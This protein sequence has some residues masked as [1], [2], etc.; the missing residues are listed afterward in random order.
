MHPSRPRRRWRPA[1]ATA[2]SATAL[3][4]VAGCA[5]PAVTGAAS[6]AVAGPTTAATGIPSPSRSSA[7]SAPSTTS[8]S[9]SSAPST[10]LPPP[11]KTS[12]S[13]SNGPTS[14]PPGGILSQVHIGGRVEVKGNTVQYS[15]PGVYFEGRFRGTG[16]GIVLNDSAADYE[17]QIDGATVATLVTP[18]QTTRWVNGLSNTDHAVRLVKRNDSPGNVSEFAGFVAAPGGAILTGPGARSRQIEF[19]GDSLTVGYGNTSTSRDCTG[20]QIHRT[21]DTDLSYGAVTARQ[22]SADY[23][24]NA[25]SG[26]GMVRNFNGGSPGTTYRTYYDQG[27]LNGSGDVWNP[28]TWRPQLVVVY[29]GTNDFS[30]ALNPGEPWTAD[31]LVTDYRSAY[32][33]FLQKLRARYGA[34][35]TIVAVGTGSFANY[36]QQVVQ[37]RVSAG[38]SRVRYWSLDSSGLDFTGCDDHYSTHDDRVIA[39]RLSAFLGSLSLGW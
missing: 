13:S 19:I 5:T 21:T 33:A 7:P 18:G 17:V 25:I 16:V 15:W 20:D 14:Q 31:S 36:V 10:P 12:G 38:D 2:V 8:P 28:G 30:T 24:I 29:L 26:L 27:L 1:F 4:A 34:K 23:Q 35:T 22:L 6:S 37:E 11:A 32:S 39:G 3:A 9:R